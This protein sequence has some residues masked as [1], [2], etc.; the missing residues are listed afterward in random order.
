MYISIV[1][2]LKFRNVIVIRIPFR[3]MEKIVVGLIIIEMKINITYP[4]WTEIVTASTHRWK[5]VTRCVEP[6]LEQ[7]FPLLS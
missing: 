7:S 4:P 5:Y 3:Q 2:R 1:N 6:G